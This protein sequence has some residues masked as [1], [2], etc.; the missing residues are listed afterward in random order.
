MKKILKIVFI[1]FF[2]IVA[3]AYLSF[4]AFLYV[5]EQKLENIPLQHESTS[6]RI[7]APHT[8]QLIDDGLAS[9][10]KRLDLIQ[11]AKESIELEFFIYELDRSSR[12][13]TERLINKAKEGIKVKLL[14]DF[15]QPV[16]KLQ[17]LYANY[18]IKN[19][20]EVKYY[21][22]SPL[23]SWFSVQHRNHRKFLIVDD[24][25]ALTGGRNIADEYFN[26]SKNYNFLDSDVLIEGPIVANL[27]KSFDLYWNSD[28]ASTPVPYSGDEEELNNLISLLRNDNELISELNQMN[29][30][31][32][33]SLVS[34]QCQDISFV[35]DFPGLNEKDRQVF[36]VLSKI[37]NEAKEKVVAESPYFVIRHGGLMLLEDM[38]KRK[39]DLKILTNGLFSTDA[40]YTV[41]ALYLTK[42]SLAENNLKLYTYSGK[43][44]PHLNSKY[45]NSSQ[46]WGIHS[47]RAVIDDSIVLLGTY[48]IDPR[49]ANLNS[50]VILICHEG[51]EFAK[52]VSESIN[53]R[54]ASAQPVLS[55]HIFDTKPLFEQSTFSQKLSFVLALPVTY[56]FDFLL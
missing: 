3:L 40:F 53:L 11:N 8:I 37:L 49:S 38:T 29:E 5:N 7:K 36:K 56:F 26:I 17:P 12:L 43:S 51:K 18:L 24:K 10:K 46:R 48:N 27:R 34:S 35:T 31:L 55:D 20:V 54:L 32:E 2:S 6:V 42:S 41:S 44:P 28:L 52:A 15:S 47:K 30:A 33:S 23:V 16:F 13:I 22:T 39:I 14:V 45:F 9:L 19:G 4:A 21:N 1:T 50:E 25:Y